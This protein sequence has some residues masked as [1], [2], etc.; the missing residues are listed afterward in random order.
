MKQKS[1]YIAIVLALHCA[2]AYADNTIDEYQI[3]MVTVIGD[4][5]SV[6]GQY[7]CM[8][9]E[10]CNSPNGPSSVNGS[11]NSIN[12]LSNYVVT[13]SNNNLGY[14]YD[15]NL[16]YFGYANSFNV[17]GNYNTGAELSGLNIFGSGNDVYGQ[18]IDIVG[19]SNKIKGSAIQVMGSYNDLDVVGMGAVLGS[20]NMVSNYAGSIIGTYNTLSGGSYALTIGSLNNITA[21][22]FGD[23]TATFKFGNITIGTINTITDSD[24]SIVLGNYN[25]VS[26]DNAIVIGNYASASNGGIAIGYGSISNSADT[27]SFG[28]STV[29]R[30]LTNVADGSSR[31]DAVNYGQLMNSV[32][33]LQAYTDSAISS[34][35]SS[36][37]SGSNTTPPI[38]GGNDNN[39][40]DGSGTGSGTGSGNS[41]D[42]NQ[43]ATDANT[44]T[45]ER[46]VS[47]NA[48]TDSLIATESAS[49]VTG[50]AQTLLSANSHTDAREAIINSRTDVLVD[51]ERQSRIDGDRQTLASANSYTNQKFSDLKKTVDRN[52]KRAKAGSASAIAIASIPFLNN[53]SGFGMAMGAYRDQGAISGGANYA[54][55]EK[56]NVRFSMSADTAGGVGAGA[57]F[58]V[59]FQ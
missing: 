47:I 50:D 38:T 11:Y 10:N 51:T 25:T 32:S 20:R 5:N 22:P 13:G 12:G 16:I 34:Y 2:A 35:L 52:D 31:Y 53:V 44:Y 27:V 43:T 59:G 48:R 33:S 9:P 42:N 58:A 8:N 17:Y 36:I 39:G 30:T 40:T 55:N 21:S 56:V 46:E 3:D 29:Q 15:P 45:D 23:P 4:E 26:D 41:N 18:N 1:L 54:I 49:R 6:T 37:G 7:Q 57:G 28:S 14:T 24:E 19:Y